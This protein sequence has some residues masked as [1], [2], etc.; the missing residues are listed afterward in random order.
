MFSF[1]ENRTLDYCVYK[2]LSYV[3]LCDRLI[4][5]G[6]V[7]CFMQNKIQSLAGQHSDVL[8]NLTPNVRK[9]V[10]VLREIQVYC[11]SFMAFEFDPI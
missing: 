8:E 5:L 11:F 2:I 1:L 3:V 4:V 7:W 9:R 6:F 10:E